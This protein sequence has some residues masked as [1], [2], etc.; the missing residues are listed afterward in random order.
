MIR[1]ETRREE[2][3]SPFVM[4]CFTTDEARIHN[5]QSN[6][7]PSARSDLPTSHAESPTILA[8]SRFEME[9]SSTNFDAKIRAARKTRRGQRSGDGRTSM[10]SRLSKVVDGTPVTKLPM[11]IML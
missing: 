6:A 3:Y 8:H 11:N 5:R 7:S 2:F 9:T 1:L 4:R 10:T